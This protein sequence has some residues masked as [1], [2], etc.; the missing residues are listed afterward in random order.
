M[1]VHES[2]SFGLT[3]IGVPMRYEAWLDRTEGR[4]TFVKAHLRTNPASPSAA[5]SRVTAEAEGIFIAA[6]GD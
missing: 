2:F 1:D 3:P 6:R 5:E 4:K